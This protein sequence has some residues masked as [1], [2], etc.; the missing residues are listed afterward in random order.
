VSG[1]TH[2]PLSLGF[3]LWHTT[4]RW[5]RQV[6]AAL[7]PLELTHVQFVLLAVLWWFVTVRGERPSQRALAEQA[8][9]DRMMTSQVVRALEGKGLVVRRR[10]PDDSRALQ[11]DLTPG[12][13]QLA[14]KAITVVEAADHDF[15]AAARDADR[16]RREL[17]ALAALEGR[18]VPAELGGARGPRSDG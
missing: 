8:G 9:T 16:L 12:G 17:L 10:H 6:V 13:A 2:A 3:L 7:R 18:P 4:L 1:D 15:F 11:L 14:V 5:Q